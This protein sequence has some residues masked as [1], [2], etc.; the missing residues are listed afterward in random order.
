[1]GARIL[2]VE[3]FVIAVGVSFPFCCGSAIFVLALGFGGSEN[4][5]FSGLVEDEPSLRSLVLL[6]FQSLGSG[7]GT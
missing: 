6:W 7:K 3:L 4:S 1:M 2:P 5:L